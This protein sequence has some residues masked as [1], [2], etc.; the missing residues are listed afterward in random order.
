[1]IGTW[2]V[3]N[4]GKWPRL[5]EKERYVLLK[6][7][8]DEESGFP[9]FM[10]G[11]I[12]ALIPIRNTKN[13]QTFYYLDRYGITDSNQFNEKILAFYEFPGK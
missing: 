7:K 2:V 13:L 11:I 1:M 8:E 5:P 4:D 10:V 12:P 3:K 9:P 6:M